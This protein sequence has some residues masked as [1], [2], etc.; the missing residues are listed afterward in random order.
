MRLLAGVLA[1]LFVAASPVCA[2]ERTWG[3]KVGLN[4][5]SLA[6]D[7]GQG[8]FGLKAGVVAGGYFTLPVGSRLELQPEALFSQQGTR[9]TSDDANATINLDYLVVPILVK[10]RFSPP[11]KGLAVYGGPSIGFNLRARTVAE[12]GDEKVDLDISDKVEK[13]DV[14]LAF[15]AMFERGRWTIDGRYTLGFSDLN[16]EDDEKINSRV[17]SI[18]A[19]IRF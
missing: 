3:A 4:L 5:A 1:V 2:Q 14:G 9:A 12:F 6:I 15:G 13:T 17:I 10:V 11:G 7:P 16:A 8:D 19:G 18:L